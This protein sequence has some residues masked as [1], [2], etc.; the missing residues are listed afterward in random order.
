M[1]IH[2]VDA[3]TATDDA[4]QPT[5]QP[6]SSEGV[7]QEGEGEAVAV[8]DGGGG[9]TAEEGGGGEAGGRHHREGCR[10]EAEAK[11]AEAVVGQVLFSDSSAMCDGLGAVGCEVGR[12]VRATGSRGIASAS[13]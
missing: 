4:G 3:S 10:S 7:C 11:Q 12:G 6:A 8:D 2:I 13:A 1:L 5:Q 9:E